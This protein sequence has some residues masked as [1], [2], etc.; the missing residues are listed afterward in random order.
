MQPCIQLPGN[1]C[2]SV[3]ASVVD[4]EKVHIV[5]CTELPSQLGKG[6]RQPGQIGSFVQ[7]GD[8]DMKDGHSVCATRSMHISFH[9]T[10]VR[11][12]AHLRHVAIGGD[13]SRLKVA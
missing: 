12:G 1:V 3:G 5:L 10:F 13:N 8:D 2:G 7:D 6:R 4:K 11:S 9:F